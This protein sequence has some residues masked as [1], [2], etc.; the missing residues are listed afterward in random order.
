MHGL[1]GVSGQ[2]KQTHAHSV[3]QEEE[4][5]GRLVGAVGSLFR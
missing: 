5:G 2:V 3:E 1:H 4:E